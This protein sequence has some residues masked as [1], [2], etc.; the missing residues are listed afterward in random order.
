MRAAATALI[1]IST[2]LLTAQQ[3]AQAPARPA[4]EVASVKETS[5]TWSEIAPKRSGG[6]IAW[7][8][9]LWDLIGYA[10][11]LP[12]F[13]ISG[14]IPGREYLYRVEAAAPAETTDDQIR[15]MLQSL[16]EERFKMVSRRVQKDADGYVLSAGRNG[17]RVAEAKAGDKPA[18]L[19]DW[20]RKNAPDPAEIE[21]RVIMSTDGP[22]IRTIAGR[23]VTMAQLSQA[24][25]RLLQAVVVD[26]TGLTGSYYFGLRYADEEHQSDADVPSLFVAISKELGLRF[27]K[28]KMPVEM[29]VVDRMERKPVEN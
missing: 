19:P 4:F 1:L 8:A 27:E 15:L 7:T 22:G 18:P 12:A 14:Q 16:L 17:I 10:Y 26:E 9:N 5:Q 23:R 20:F 6:R 25:Q 11:R 28:R 13:R 21:G 3:S 29:L 2:S 24:L